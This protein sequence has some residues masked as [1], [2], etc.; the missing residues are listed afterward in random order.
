LPARPPTRIPR[1]P[2]LDRH[3]NSTKTDKVRQREEDLDNGNSTAYAHR[4]NSKT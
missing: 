1:L 4:K 2:P 3:L